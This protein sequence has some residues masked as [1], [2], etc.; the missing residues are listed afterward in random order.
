MSCVCFST[1][2]ETE[3]LAQNYKEIYTVTSGGIF[4]RHVLRGHNRFIKLKV[5]SI[6]GYTDA[7]G[8]A[9]KQEICFL[10]AGKIPFDLWKQIIGFFKKVIEVKK[11]EVEAMIHIL[12]N[13][14]LGYHIGVPPQTVSKTSASYDW[15][16][17]P[18][19]TSIILDCH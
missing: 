3:A 10:P 7:T 5:E 12:Y 17:V 1:E 6:S 14:T 4:K 15:S 9:P 2:E 18:A 8:A 19:G 16:Y 13:D 11:S